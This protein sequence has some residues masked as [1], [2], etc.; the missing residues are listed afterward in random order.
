MRRGVKHLAELAD[1]MSG[2]ATIEHRGES[3]A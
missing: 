2:F 3:P 1:N